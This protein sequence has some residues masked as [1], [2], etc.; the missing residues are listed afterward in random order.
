MIESY[1]RGF[2]V[3]GHLQQEM[4][5]TAMIVTGIVEPLSIRFQCNDIDSGVAAIVKPNVE[6]HSKWAYVSRSPSTV[7][8]SYFKH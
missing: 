6:S 2:I 8:I 1:T 7:S 4:P 3:D 5:I